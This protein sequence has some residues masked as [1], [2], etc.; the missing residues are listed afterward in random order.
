MDAVN[1]LLVAANAALGSRELLVIIDNLD[2]YHPKVIDELLVREQSLRWELDRVRGELE[3]LRVRPV[4]DLEAEL[5]STQAQLEQVE[6]A[7]AEA[8]TALAEDGEAGEGLEFAD[9]AARALAE[10]EPSVAQ[11]REWMKA[12]AKLDHLLR[13]LER[14]GEVSALELHRELSGLRRLL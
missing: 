14:G 13:K 12:R 9:L 5:A 7:L 6:A 1:Q 8:E 10:N 2:R 4:E 3:N 11:A